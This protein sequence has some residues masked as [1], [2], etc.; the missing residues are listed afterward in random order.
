MKRNMKHTS[1]CHLVRYATVQLYCKP[2]FTTRPK[3]QRNITKLQYIFCN[4]FCDQL[5]NSHLL[6]SIIQPSFLIQLFWNWQQPLATGITYAYLNNS[7]LCLTMHGRICTK[8]FS[9]WCPILPR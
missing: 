1:G 9:P 5:Q 4:L 3:F 8:F 6:F 2:L 7:M